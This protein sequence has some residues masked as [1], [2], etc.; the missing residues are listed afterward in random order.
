MFPSRSYMKYFFGG[1]LVGKIMRESNIQLEWF[2]CRNNRM[3]FNKFILHLYLIYYNFLLSGHYVTFQ[4]TGTI[5]PQTN[6]PWV[7]S[8][9]FRELNSLTFLVMFTIQKKN[10]PVVLFYRSSVKSLLLLCFAVILIVYNEADL[11]NSKLLKC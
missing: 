7:M 4:V 5:L 3:N 6:A 9:I 11:I 10:K 1:L 8:R 2:S